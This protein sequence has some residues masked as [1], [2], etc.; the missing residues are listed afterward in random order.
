[1]EIKITKHI[2]IVEKNNEI[3]RTTKN[4]FQEF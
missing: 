2:E 4:V 1:M 3:I